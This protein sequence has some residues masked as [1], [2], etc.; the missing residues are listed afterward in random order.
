MKV[1]NYM[2]DI[3]DSMLPR[4]LLEDRYKNQCVCKQCINDIK[5]IA[6]NNLK[7]KYIATEKGSI[8]S[9]ASMFTVQS[10]TDVTKAL[11]DALEK[12]SM[13]PRHKVIE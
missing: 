2:E 4:I 12:V 13:F 8:L 1:H 3:V 11:V 9:K 7:P 5:A 10:E 6:L